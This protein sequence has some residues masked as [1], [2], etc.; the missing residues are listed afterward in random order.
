MKLLIPTKI[1]FIFRIILNVSIPLML[2][3]LT[4]CFTGVE[5]TKKIT[6]SKEDRKSIQPSTE[7]LFFQS[8]AGTPLSDWEINRP[9][10]AADNKTLLIFEQQGLPLDHE[11]LNLAGKTLYYKG[12]ESRLRPDGNESLVII[13]SDNNFDYKYNTEKEITVALKEV[14]SDQI[15]MMIDEAMINDTRELLFG[16][17]LW[18][19][20]PLWYDEKGERIRGKKFV[21]VTIT[22]VEP[23]TL[24]FPVK[25]GLKA[26]DGTEAWMYMNFGNSGTDS[27]SFSNIFYLSDF[28]KNYPTVT[29]EVWQLICDG[30]IQAGMTKQECKL[31]LGNP[32]EVDAGHD[33]SHTLDLW[34]YPDGTVLW[35]E[36]GLLTRFHQ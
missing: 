7:E 1:S 8:V 14:S 12:T 27:R 34:T 32:S 6:L 24:V 25:L 36:D 3:C 31:S 13:F 29:D 30:K 35:F 21:P 19:R 20:S 16:R 4:S 33:Y 11:A 5:S 10:I 18:T 23:G 26:E 2:C 17:K 28:R 9:F 22:S 15:P